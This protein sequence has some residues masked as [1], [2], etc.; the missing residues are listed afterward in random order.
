[1]MTNDQP[2]MT[3]EER[4]ECIRKMQ[5]ASDRFYAAATQTGNHAFIEFCGLMNEYILLCQ[6]A[7]AE[8][9]DFANL[10]VHTGRHLKLYPHQ[11][12][13]IAEK[14]ECIYGRAIFSNGRNIG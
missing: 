3:P 12:S 2:W 14:L 5:V 13:Y 4:A 9:R 10:N 6:E 11:E 1:M 8:G 7:H